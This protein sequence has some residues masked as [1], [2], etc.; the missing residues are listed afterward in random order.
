MESQF[1]TLA[2]SSAKAAVNM[3]TSQYAKAF[4][5]LKINAPR[6]AATSTGTVPFPGKTQLWAHRSLTLTSPRWT[7]RAR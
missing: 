7:G 4:P 6:P 5:R 1:P 2:Y 3:L